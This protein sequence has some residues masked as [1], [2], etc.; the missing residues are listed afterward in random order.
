MKNVPL[1]TLGLSVLAV[2]TQVISPR[3]FQYDRNG[4]INGEL[5]RSIT[6]QFTHW[7]ADH[8][9]WDVLVF[10]AL[11]SL[12]ERRNRRLFIQ[13]VVAATILV[14]IGVHVACPEISTFRGLSGIDS[15]LAGLLHASLFVAARRA[16]SH[17]WQV[18]TI[19]GVAAFFAKCG[20]EQV[21]GLTLFASSGEEWRVVPLSHAVGFCC[22]MVC[23]AWPRHGREV[24]FE[25]AS[26]STGF[27]AAVHAT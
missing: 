9:L 8:L 15:A 6:C 2:A 20:W 24:H 1:I 10:V 27:A 4:L 16:R 12:C 13:T 18:V 7:S 5:W 22:G 11:G 14:P 17:A 26:S 3:L 19:A 23:G 25:S 21:T